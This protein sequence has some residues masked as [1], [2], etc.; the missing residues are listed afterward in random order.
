MLTTK[1]PKCEKEV[2]VPAAATAESRVR[3]P[4][5]EEEYTLESVF[6]DL[7]PLLE[8]L[9]APS[10]NGEA[11]ATLADEP[12]AEDM[13]GESDRA[14]SLGGGMFDFDKGDAK[15]D[16][17]GIAIAD[18]VETIEKSA[19]F[20]F[21]GDSAPAAAAVGAATAT[22]AR[23]KARP[24]RKSSPMKMII[25][26]I[27]GGLLAG[28]IAQL[29][30]W[31]VLPG[32]WHVEQRDPMGIGRSLKG[33]AASFLV[34]SWV[35]DANSAA[36]AGGQSSEVESTKGGGKRSQDVADGAAGSFPQLGGAHNKDNENDQAANKDD[37][38]NAN[39]D[40][41]ESGSD[42]DGDVAV[43]DFDPFADGSEAGGSGSNEP[44]IPPPPIV[45]DAPVYT[46]ADVGG[47]LTVVNEQI[48]RFADIEK[49]LDDTVVARD[50]KDKF[51]A[52]MNKLAEV[53]TFAEEK[54]EGQ[55]EFLD[56]FLA[57][58]GD[59]PFKRMVL[60]R[61]AMERIQQED[62]EGNGVLLV[63]TVKDIKEVDGLFETIVAVDAKDEPLVSVYGDR[64]PGAA[65]SAG[66]TVMIL[67]AIIDKPA[68]KI[69]GYQGAPGPVVWGGYSQVI[70]AAAPE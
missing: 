62:R 40:N 30:L 4:L 34:P 21:G 65:F 61:A 25:G 13:T 43:P 5:C 39:N 60:G 9:D 67:C 66:E 63:G 23:K 3:C 26:V 58:A 37:G 19:A 31:W 56:E 55:K 11:A 10:T 46:S 64:R 42:N 44:D 38:Q 1:C 57:Q 20:D 51:V 7:P 68:E 14:G 49:K 33:T 8:L 50:I 59:S 45:V 17:G 12:Q 53:V 18:P 16:D 2:T 27:I 24:R 48:K 36:N 29:F 35:K 15:D 52:A 69:R 70:T 47:A 6:G 32:N 41:G 22:T 28:P 54:S